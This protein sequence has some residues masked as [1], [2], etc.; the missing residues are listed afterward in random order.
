[1]KERERVRERE[2]EV[3]GAQSKP[4]PSPNA[5]IEREGEIREKERKYGLSKCS[6]MY[7]SQKGPLTIFRR[8]KLY[9]NDNFFLDY[10]KH[11]LTNLERL[12]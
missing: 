6:L 10:P 9:W 12:K 4:N 8:V 5:Y 3:K 1:M 7:K 2:R 11:S